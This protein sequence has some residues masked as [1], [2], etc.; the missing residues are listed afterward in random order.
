LLLQYKKPSKTMTGKKTPA[1]LLDNQN[2]I[3]LN[4]QN[5]SS[6]DTSCRKTRSEKTLNNKN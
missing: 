4:N 3:N 6:S 1:I 2:N 5:T